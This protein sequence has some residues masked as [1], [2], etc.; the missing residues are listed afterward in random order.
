MMGTIRSMIVKASAAAT[1]PLFV[2]ACIE[3]YAERGYLAMG[4]EFLVLLLPLI[5][6]GFVY[7]GGE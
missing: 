7:E 6:A 2:W 5:V 1:P 4:G 3:A